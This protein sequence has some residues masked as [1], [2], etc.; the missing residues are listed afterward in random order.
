MIDPGTLARS[1]GATWLV[2][3]LFT[4]CGGSSSETPF[5]A[6]P[7]PAYLTDAK[8][9]RASSGRSSKKMRRAKAAEQ[10]N[11][12]GTG[13]GAKTSPDESEPKRPRAAPARRPAAEPPPRKKP[14][15]D[16]PYF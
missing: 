13:D 8:G 4:G 1:A 15:P 14:D 10:A 11:D 6:E 2:V 5:P 7:L 16:E 12:D 9:D 3:G